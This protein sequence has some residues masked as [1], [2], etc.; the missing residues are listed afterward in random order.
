[1]SV[2]DADRLFQMNTPDSDANVPSHKYGEVILAPVIM[3]PLSMSTVLLR[4][5]VKKRILKIFFLDDW[6][7]VLSFVLYTILCS[8]ALS[9]A[10]YGF[11]IHTD[12]LAEDKVRKIYQVSSSVP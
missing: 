3:L 10:G 1:M 2:T 6:L 8:L 9:S 5:W 11:G 7:L 12:V 4:C